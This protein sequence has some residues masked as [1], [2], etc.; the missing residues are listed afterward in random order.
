MGFN[1]TEGEWVSFDLSDG[2]GVFYASKRDELRG[3]KQMILHHKEYLDSLLA[4]IEKACTSLGENTP[5]SS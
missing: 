4:G 3:T 5:Q 2:A 1:C